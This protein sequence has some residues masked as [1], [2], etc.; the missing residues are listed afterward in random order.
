M[1][2]SW[3]GLPRAVA[4]GLAAGLAASLSGCA[5]GI[6]LPLV[7]QP[8]IAGAKAGD[9]Y[10]AFLAARYA[11][12]R[13]DMVSAAAYYRRA[14]VDKPA[15]PGLMERAIFATLASGDASEAVRITLQSRREVVSASPTAQLVLVVDTICKGN[16]RNA[17]R[18][19]EAPAPDEV[20]DDLA[21]LLKAWLTAVDDPD[22]ARHSLQS[23]ISRSR[24]AGVQASVEALILMS[25]GRDPDSLD[26]FER[27]LSLPLPSPA[28]VASLAAQLAASREDFA[29]A[30]KLVNARVR[31]DGAGSEAVLAMINGGKPFARPALSLRQGAGLIIY[32]ASAGSTHTSPDLAAMRYSLALLLDPELAPARLTLAA[33]LSQT[34]RLDEAGDVL[35]QVNS[36]SPWRAPAFLQEAWIL[37]SLRRPAEAL[38]AA[39]QA[40]AASHDRSIL[41]GAADLHRLEGNFQRARQLYDEV[42]AADAAA[43][44]PDWQILFAS[45]SALSLSGDRA[46]AEAQAGAAL[47][48]APDQPELLNF[49]GYAW[50][51]RG[52]RVEEGLALILK[53]AALRPDEGYI[54]DS[55]GWAYYRLGRYDE[56][57]SSLERAAEL[58][59]ANTDILEHLGDA[60]W[61]I[62]REVDAS[63]QWSAA[64]NL[65]QDDPART[66]SLRNK[67]A[68]G[69]PALPAG[70]LVSRP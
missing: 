64:L 31:D 51:D 40:L 57:V 37:H 35:R 56:A 9:D 60:Y 16:V 21:D 18:Y 29:R 25:A 13:G 68:K 65:G 66:E 19:I 67:I 8:A 11:A 55:L 30:R 49:L 17:L 50:V 52:E 48:L 46:K 39:E 24:F 61:R 70:R 47:A 69:L 5:S 43:G 38:A 15:D 59:P 36:G 6:A 32:L 45:A 27:A 10:A 34:G 22:K 44:E 62:G 20:N 2:G 7:P 1:P 12:M 3:S 14:L 4:A 33:A 41:I 42:V 26:A 63:Y 23:M 54:L 28:P 58:E 53:A